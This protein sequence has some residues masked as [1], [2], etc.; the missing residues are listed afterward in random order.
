MP[1]KTCFARQINRVSSLP[2]D[3]NQKDNVN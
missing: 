1:A 2:T 3:L